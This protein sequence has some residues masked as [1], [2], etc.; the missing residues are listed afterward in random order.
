MPPIPL[1][2]AKHILEYIYLFV[3]SNNQS[4]P[5]A[6]HLNQWL[7]HLIH[8]S[9]LW[10]P[11]HRICSWRFGGFGAISHHHLVLYLV[12]TLS[13]MGWPVPMKSTSFEEQQ[14]IFLVRIQQL[15]TTGQS[16]W[17]AKLRRKWRKQKLIFW[18]DQSQQ[19]FF[20]MHL[21]NQANI[22]QSSCD[23]DCPTFILTDISQR[24]WNS[25]MYFSW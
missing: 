18:G 25:V 4:I 17:K 16:T 7:L 14:M 23:Q 1:N 21:I 19:V 6:A 5:I 2:Q 22:I 12:F 8:W 10:G 20:F 9:L 13:W 3:H 11:N 15:A 24:E